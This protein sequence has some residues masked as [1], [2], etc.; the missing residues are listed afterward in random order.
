MV[1]YTLYSAP[2]YTEKMRWHEEQNGGELETA[3]ITLKRLE[4]EAYLRRA[5]KPSSILGN[6]QGTWERGESWAQSWKAKQDVAP[7]ICMPTMLSVRE[8]FWL[9]WELRRKVGKEPN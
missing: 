8:L 7:K 6:V 1:L 5:S 3:T 4:I 9:G 2:W